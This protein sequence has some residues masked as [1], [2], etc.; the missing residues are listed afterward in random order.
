MLILP[1]GNGGHLPGVLV[2]LKVVV[3]KD[4]FW[5]GNC[6]DEAMG[7]PSIKGEVMRYVN[8]RKSQSIMSET[9]KSDEVTPT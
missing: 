1:A 6:N 5:A 2:R 8:R 4:A 7:E 9:R 3:V